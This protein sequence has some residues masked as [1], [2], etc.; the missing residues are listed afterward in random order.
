MDPRSD[1]CRIASVIG[2]PTGL[3]VEPRK[4]AE[5]DGLHLDTNSQPVAHLLGDGLNDL[6]GRAVVHLDSYLHVIEAVA[7]VD[8]NCE[9]P[10]SGTL[11]TRFSTADGNKLTPRTI[12]ASSTRPITPPS[13]R[14]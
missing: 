3:E 8:I 9:L 1:I 5:R 10:T 11:L 6:L 14:L 7:S 13:K 12:K 2:N 4:R